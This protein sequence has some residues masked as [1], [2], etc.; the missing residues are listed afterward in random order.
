M[1]KKPPS[2]VA[3]NWSRPFF[4]YCQS[5]QTQPKSQFLFYKNLQ[6]RDFSIVTLTACMGYN[7]HCRGLAWLIPFTTFLCVCINSPS[8]IRL[9]LQLPRPVVGL[10]GWGWALL[11]P[12]WRGLYRVESLIYQILNPHAEKDPWICT[13]RQ[14]HRQKSPIVE[15]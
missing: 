14:F 3:H 11:R 9:L 7:C 2:K 12:L 6:P 8:R 15:L 4:Q 10:V 13:A 1:L 5:A